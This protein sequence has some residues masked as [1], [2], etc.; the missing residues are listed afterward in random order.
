MDEIDYRDAYAPPQG[1]SFQGGVGSMPGDPDLSFL[2]GWERRRVLYNAVLAAIVLVSS[3]MDLGRVFLDLVFWEFL[4][5]AAF[6]AN[7]C[8]CTGPIAEAYLRWIG[9]RREWLGGLLFGVG[10]LISVPL[11]FLSVAAYHLSKSGF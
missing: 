6:C 2:A 5:V 9:I 10:L 7:V 4:I 11:T 8:F 1:K 3:L